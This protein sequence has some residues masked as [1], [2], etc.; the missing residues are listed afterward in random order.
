MKEL[1]ELEKSGK[2]KPEGCKDQLTAVLGNEEHRGRTRDVSSIAPWKTTFKKDVFSYKERETRK[3]SEAERQDEWE[4]HFFKFLQE[5]PNV[6]QTAASQITVPQIQLEIPSSMASVQQKFPVDDITEDTSCSLHVPIGRKGNSREVARSFA[7]PGTVFHNRPIPEEYAKVQ[8]TEITDDRF[9]NDPLDVPIPDEG[10]ET[11]REVLNNFVLWA[12]RD[13]YL[14]QRQSLAYSQSYSSVLS[15]QSPTYPSP[16]IGSLSPIIEREKEQ[17]IEKDKAEKEDEAQKEAQKEPVKATP[18]P[19]KEAEAQKEKEAV[20]EPVTQKEV[21]KEVETTRSVPIIHKTTVPAGQSSQEPPS[22]IHKWFAAFQPTRSAPVGVEAP[23]QMA[24]PLSEDEWT[25]GDEDHIDYVKGAQF[26]P[27]RVLQ[28][29]HWEMKA[30]HEWYLAASAL[31]VTTIECRVPGDV[32]NCPD[33]ELALF[34]E[35]FHQLFRLKRMDITSI[36]L[37]Y[38]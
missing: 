27:R 15:S 3:D 4:K 8:V 26:V 24:G 31:G 38:L 6:I 2:F 35:D 11:I 30:F 9:I 36:I 7:M 29:M 18:E 16:H 34:F 19:E 25:Y 28:G 14:I 10:I 23:V 1:A 22:Q 21:V 32:F 20:K 17:G 37:F 33:F 12:K 13:I 5:N